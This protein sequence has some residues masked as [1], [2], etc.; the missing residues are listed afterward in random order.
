M[1][2]LIAANELL[3]HP[4]DEVT[5]LSIAS[6]LEGHPDNITPTIIGGLVLASPER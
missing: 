1:G 5:L 2:A 3:G 4:A 6:E